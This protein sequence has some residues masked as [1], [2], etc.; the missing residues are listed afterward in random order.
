MFSVVNL[1]TSK[2]KIFEKQ[3]VHIYHTIVYPLGYIPTYIL[4]A[5]F[6][7]V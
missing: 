7:Y 4:S 5:I 3:K 2:D 1:Q 6:S